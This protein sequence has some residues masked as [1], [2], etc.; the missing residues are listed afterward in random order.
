MSALY[1]R[2]LLRLG[3]LLA[4]HPPLDRPDGVARRRSSV[5]GSEVEASVRIADGRISALGLNTVACALG[6]ASAALFAG[7]ATGLSATDVA[8]ARG[9]LDEWLAGE[10]DDPP[11][12]YEPLAPARAHA[13]RYPSMLLPYDATLAALERVA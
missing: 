5:C 9:H 6:Q 4:D 1:S 2:E 12:G 13:A 3:T 10:R 11:A 8:Q 7:R